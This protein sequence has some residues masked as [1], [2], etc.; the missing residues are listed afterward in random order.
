MCDPCPHADGGSGA[1]LRGSV[2]CPGSPREGGTPSTHT[3]RLARS[4][5][6]PHLPVFSRNPR[7]SRL[8]GCNPTF[9]HSLSLPSLCILGQ[10]EVTESPRSGTP[11][12]RSPGSEGGV[13]WCGGSCQS[14]RHPPSR[15]RGRPQ[16]HRASHNNPGHANGGQGGVAPGPPP[17]SALVTA[18]NR[19]GLLGTHR[20]GHTWTRGHTWDE[21]HTWTRGH[22]W[23]GTHVDEGHTWTGDTGDTRGQEHTRG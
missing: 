9:S 1:F 17:E 15:R 8:G 22:T 4:P 2:T 23:T 10:M 18:E 3:G 20:R 13:P 11:K 7:G 6:D 21:G 19:P 12:T 5:S 14:A 16:G